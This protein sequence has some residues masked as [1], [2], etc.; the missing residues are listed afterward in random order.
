M[1][2]EA[3]L[4]DDIVVFFTLVDPDLRHKLRDYCKEKGIHFVDIMSAPIHALADASGLQPSNNPG[5]L[6]TTDEHYFRR[7]AAMEFTVEHDDGRNPQDLTEAD[8]VPSRACP[9]RRKLPFPSIW[10]WRVTRSQTFRWHSA[11]SLRRRYTNATLSHFRPYDDRR[12]S[13]WEYV[14]AGSGV[15]A[16]RS[17]R[18]GKLRGAPKTVYQD[19]E[20][21]RAL[22]RKLGMHRRA[23]RQ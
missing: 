6:R 23:H 18:R 15:G 12:I 2:R 22:M 16:R 1:Y 20:E 13:W 21:A 8:I 3:G 11:W 17:E 9:V 5:L 19:L 4:R 10:V 7:I 14:H